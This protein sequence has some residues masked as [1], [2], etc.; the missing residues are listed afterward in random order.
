MISLRDNTQWALRAD[1]VLLI[2]PS[3][4]AVAIPVTGAGMLSRSD[5]AD[6]MLKSTGYHNTAMCS[7]GE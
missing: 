1:S 4:G 6:E 7:K 3:G 2:G 5:N